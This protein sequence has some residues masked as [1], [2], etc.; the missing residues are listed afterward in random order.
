MEVTKDDVFAYINDCVDENELRAIQTALNDQWAALQ[1]V[2]NKEF[3]IGDTV[4][5]QGKL[6]GTRGKIKWQGKI[7]GKRGKWI[8]IEARPAGSLH[9]TF[10]SHN[11]RC[12][13]S[14]LTKV[15][16]VKEP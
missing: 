13:P 4:T 10:Q 2:L 16:V 8:D 15:E 3:H 1:A 14:V 5:F 9:D 11:W 12:S 6:R 7:T